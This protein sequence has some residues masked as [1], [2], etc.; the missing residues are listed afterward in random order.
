MSSDPTLTPYQ[1]PTMPA[2]Q[3]TMTPYRAISV[4]LTQLATLAEPLTGD[5]VYAPVEAPLSTAE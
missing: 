5:V 1:T 2:E 4:R 3:S